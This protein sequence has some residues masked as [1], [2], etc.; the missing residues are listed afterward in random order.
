MN[1][2]IDDLLLGYLQYIAT[3]NPH[4]KRLY[5]W[6]K[7]FLKNRKTIGKALGITTQTLNR[8]IAK[9]KEN[10]LLSEDTENYYFP[11]NEQGKY[12]IINSD[13]LSYLITTSNCNAIKIYIYLLNKYQWKQD[14][15]FTLRE[16][17]TAIGY[18]ESSNN[19]LASDIVKNNLKRFCNDDIMN[20]TIIQDFTTAK[21]GS[22]VP[23]YR[24]QLNFVSQEPPKD[25]RNIEIIRYQP[26]Q[27]GEAFRKPSEP[28]ATATFNF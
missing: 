18:S 3:Y 27:I 17:Q 9:L 1:Y 23:V 26:E 14:Y 21:D 20:I 8:H 13:M 19:K 6:K 2:S 22:I 7:I 24:Y 16:L 11:Y 25:I 10:N 15:V 5:L 4:E 28:E 12:K